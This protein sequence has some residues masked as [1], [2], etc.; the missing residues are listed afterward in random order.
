M[1][2]GYISLLQNTAKNTDGLEPRQC[3]LVM[4]VQVAKVKWPY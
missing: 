2:G 1:S 4:P 3:L